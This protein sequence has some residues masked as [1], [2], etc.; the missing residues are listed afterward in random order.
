[1]L[2]IACLM[3]N[4]YDAKKSSTYLKNGTDFH[5]QYGSGSLSGYLSTDTVN[6]SFIS[7]FFLCLLL[8]Q[9][10]TQL[11]GSSSDNSSDSI[12][13]SCF[14]IDQMC[15]RDKVRGEILIQ[16]KPFL[17]CFLDRRFEHC[18]ANFCGSYSR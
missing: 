2:N 12:N 4:K 18:E 5:I 14:V 11:C 15:D 10:F 1:M 7:D 9:H 3:H 6:V 16:F 17:L 13:V 8:N